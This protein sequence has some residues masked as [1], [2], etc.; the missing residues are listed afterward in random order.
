LINNAAVAPQGDSFPLLKDPIEAWEKMLRLNVSA[1]W[2]LTRSALP[3]MAKTGAGR[4][5]FISS[6]A[7]WSFSRGHGHYNV[8]KSALNNL[9]ASFA[10]EA[11]Q[12]FPKVDLQLNTLV[13]G[14]ARTEMNQGSTTSPFTVVSMALTLLA[15]PRGGPNGH[16]F[17]RD[18]RHLNF[19]YQNAFGISVN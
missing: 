8:S 15:Q 1:P 19:G 3:L 11:A 4:V 6:E 13:P 18:G 14:E 2:Y 16:F 12:A 10:E 5:L 7:G 17:H 9:S